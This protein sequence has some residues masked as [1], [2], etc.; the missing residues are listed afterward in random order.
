MRNKLNVVHK[1]PQGTQTHFVFIYSGLMAWIN[2]SLKI[3][4]LSEA[5]KQ[6]FTFEYELMYKYKN[7][8][9]DVKGSP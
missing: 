6:G 1:Q 3:E 8:I 5:T 2:L 7:Q 9:P 4:F